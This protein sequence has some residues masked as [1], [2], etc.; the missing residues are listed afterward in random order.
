M[1]KHKYNTSKN[2][3]HESA[4]SIERKIMSEAE[5]CEC[6]KEQSATSW[7]QQNNNGWF[8]GEY[9]LILKNCDS[10]NT[11]EFESAQSLPWQEH[12]KENQKTQTSTQDQL[13]IEVN[14]VCK[15]VHNPKSRHRN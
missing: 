11:K 14:R 10:N 9:K 15:D 6:Y 5:A 13:N 4:K 3:F 12:H 1:A 2:G 7:S 8:K